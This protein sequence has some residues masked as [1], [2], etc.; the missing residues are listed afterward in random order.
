MSP[1]KLVQRQKYVTINLRNLELIAST[2]FPQKASCKVVQQWTS[3]WSK[4]KFVKTIT[5]LSLEI[6]WYRSINQ[7]D[8]IPPSFVLLMLFFLSADWLRETLAS[9]SQ[10]IHCTREWKTLSRVQL[11]GK[12]LW[13]PL[14]TLTSA[15]LFSML[16]LMVMAIISLILVSL[17]FDSA[18]IL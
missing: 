1:T 8:F 13:L 5:H 7:G 4:T 9:L 10:G 18:M 3:F 17:M 6:L 11:W 12:K 15:C 16:F 14:D 2:R